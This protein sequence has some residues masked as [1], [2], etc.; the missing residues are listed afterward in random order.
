MELEYRTTNYMPPHR[1]AAYARASR[2]RQ[3]LSNAKPPTA[4]SL[5]AKHAQVVNE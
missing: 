3:R 1:L 2:A 5:H 4:I